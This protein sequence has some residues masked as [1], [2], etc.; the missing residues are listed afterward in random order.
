MSRNLSSIS[1]FLTALLLFTGCVSHPT[2][3][4]GQSMYLALQSSFNLTNQDQIDD[5]LQKYKKYKNI[6]LYDGTPK[7]TAEK[8]ATMSTAAKKIREKRKSKSINTELKQLNQSK[9]VPYRIASGDKFNISVYMEPELTVQGGV[10][11]PDGTIT[12]SMIGDV[13]VSGLTINE[14]MEKIE[15]DMKKYLQDPIVSLV[16]YE[17]RAQTYTVLGKVRSPGNL[18]LQQNT[19]VLDAIAESGGLATGS[20][21]STTI[22]LADL[23]H[24]FIKRG[25]KLLPVN[26]VELIRNGNTLHNI[27]LADK[28]Y[29]YIPSALNTEIY[30]LGEVNKPSYYGYSENMRL[31]Q[32][33]AHAGG[34][35]DTADINNVA[36]IRGSLRDPEIYVVDL[37]KIMEGKSLDFKV[38][39]F[40]IVFFPKSHFA[41]WNTL[42]N[43][44]LPSFQGITTAYLLSDML[45]GGSSN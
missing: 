18:P 30:I 31:T 13:K 2:P 22:E 10:V 41:D 32:L 1:I 23:E 17:F 40:D 28:D 39:P 9:I 34:Y 7:R 21:L 25:R 16:P 45:D 8:N 38:E 37:E 43:M 6:T 26:F 33:L 3:K 36:V 11:K 35:K 15:K 12:C 44:L 5:R 14:A 24:A 27:P 20:Y 4:P 42:L 29:I 19:R